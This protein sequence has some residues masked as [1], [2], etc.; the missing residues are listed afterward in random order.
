MTQK[1]KT[2]ENIR[3]IKKYVLN[4][5]ALKYRKQHLKEEIDKLIISW[6]FQQP[7]FRNRSK[8][9]EDPQESRR[10]TNSITD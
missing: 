4:N 8:Q 1:V 10:R 5:R 6:K 3:V 9:A 2:L 7:T